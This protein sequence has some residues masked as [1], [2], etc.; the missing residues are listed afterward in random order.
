[1]ETSFS[2]SS[3][4][5]THCRVCSNHLYS[6]QSICSMSLTVSLNWKQSSGLWQSTVSS[7]WWQLC[8]DSSSFTFTLRLD[9]F[10]CSTL[11][12][13]TSSMLGY[14]TGRVILFARPWCIASYQL[15]TMEWEAVVVSESSYQLKLPSLRTPKVSTSG[16]STICPSSCSLLQSCWTSSSELLSILSLSW[17]T[18]TLGLF[19]TRRTSASSV[20]LTKPCSTKIRS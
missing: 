4:W 2:T 1:M 17:E 3:T 18:S 5:S 15:L 9:S 20:E 12:M 13:M 8:W 7:W 6:I 10:S 19:R 16:L 14:S 11:F